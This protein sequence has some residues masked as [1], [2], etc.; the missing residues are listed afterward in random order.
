MPITPASTSEAE[1]VGFLK[2]PGQRA[3]NNALSQKG[4]GII[5]VLASRP[6]E[7]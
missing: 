4:Q 1:A 3:K 6:F 5:L 2:V 7:L